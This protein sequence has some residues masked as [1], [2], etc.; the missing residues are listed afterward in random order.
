MLFS[1]EYMQLQKQLHQDA[2]NYGEAS[3]YYASLVA[4]LLHHYKSTELLDYGCGKGRLFYELPKYIN[5]SDLFLWHY[6][7]AITGW[8]KSPMPLDFV[9]CIDVLEHI[10]PNCLDA[11]LDDLQRVGKTIGFF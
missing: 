3:E 4:R 9:A 2:P 1:A 11:V 6:D 7:P 5:I 8:D 10:E